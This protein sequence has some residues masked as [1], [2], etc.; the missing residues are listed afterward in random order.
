MHL[1]ASLQSLVQCTFIAA[2]TTACSSA[3]SDGLGPEGT[4][5]G[6]AASSSGASGSSSGGSSSGS[7]DPDG[8]GG[9]DAGPGAAPQPAYY[10]RDGKLYDPCGEQLVL[11]GVN[12]MAVFLDRKGDSFPEI[13]KTGANTVRFM[14]LT[15]VPASEAVQTLQRAVD[16]K[17]V[18]IWEMHDATGDFSKMPQIEAFWTDPA[19]V[20]VLKRF[21]ARMILNIANEAGQGVPDVTLISTYGR[22]AQKLRTAG[23]RMPL[24]VDAAGYGRDVEQLLRV[25]PQIQAADP[26]H[27]M[28]FSWHEYDAGG[29]QE[30][31][32][33][34]AFTT[35]VTQ[36]IPFLVGE[37]GNVSPGACQLQVPYQHV[38]TQAQAMGIGYLPWSWDNSNGDCNTGGGSAFDLVSD[39]I[40]L[41]TLKA[42]W[43]TDVVT[44]NAASIQK[45][46]KR[47]AFQKT[48]GV[49]TCG[50]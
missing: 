27:N 25:A 19:T 33:T 8:G 38:I 50:P 4:S 21:E 14:W 18:P 24:M 9:F 29:N 17:L 41:S 10:V 49:G 11:R 45:T 13:A 15:S 28:M 5:S 46:A 35:A 48:S 6:A 20:T 16:E 12:K 23:V 47:T 22:I 26:I 34:N 3:G 2:L 42:G 39:G 44:G 32:I 37:F 43:A 30:A 31:R 7:V 1:R 36:K 40:H